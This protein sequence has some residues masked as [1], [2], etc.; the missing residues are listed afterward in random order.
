MYTNSRNGGPD[1][2]RGHRLDAGLRERRTISEPEW[3]RSTEESGVEQ[4]AVASVLIDTMPANNEAP[5]AIE[6]P[7]IVVSIVAVEANLRHSEGCRRRQANRCIPLGKGWLA[8]RIGRKRENRGSHKT[9]WLPRSVRPGSYA[10]AATDVICGFSAHSIRTCWIARRPE[11][12]RR[13]SARRV[14]L[15]M[16]SEGC[17][18]EFAHSGRARAGAPR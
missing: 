10:A 1:G 11:R 12:V 3:Q 9:P 4:D 7:L 17:A 16:L 6:S 2:L 18:S 13:R 14:D 15:R 8:Y 5:D